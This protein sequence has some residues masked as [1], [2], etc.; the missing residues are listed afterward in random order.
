[1]S[2]IYTIISGIYIAYFEYFR[3]GRRLESIR[4]INY[5]ECI[6]FYIDNKSIMGY[7]TEARML[8]KLKILPCT[9]TI[10]CPEVF[11]QLLAQDGLNDVF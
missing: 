3:E 8:V 4:R 9:I 5:R 10:H 1:M 7:E 11:H 2:Q 6:S